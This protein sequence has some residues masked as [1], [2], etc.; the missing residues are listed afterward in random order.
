MAP[1]DWFYC[2]HLVATPMLRS[3]GCTDEL[4]SNGV[5]RKRCQIFRASA[6][7]ISSHHVPGVL[8]S[9]LFP[10][11]RLCDKLC[12][13]CTLVAVVMQTLPLSVLHLCRGRSVMFQ[14]VPKEA[15]RMVPSPS[16]SQTCAIRALL[17]EQICLAQSLSQ[18]DLRSY[19]RQTLQYI[20][21]CVMQSI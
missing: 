3:R 7:F 8:T 12:Q 21:V 19:M 15:S 6:L 18:K 5:G 11:T 9:D 13:R 2:I 20:T 4:T 16:S 17:C 14:L 1:C 10:A